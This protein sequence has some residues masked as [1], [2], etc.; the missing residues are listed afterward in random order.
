MFASLASQYIE[1][2]ILAKLLNIVMNKITI[3]NRYI[4]DILSSGIVFYYIRAKMLSAK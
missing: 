4:L 2:R 3:I 1:N